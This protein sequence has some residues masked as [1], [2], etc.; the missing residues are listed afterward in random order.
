MKFTNTVMF[1]EFYY[2]GPMVSGERNK[3]I[4]IAV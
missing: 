2:V 1:E 3:K 4:Y